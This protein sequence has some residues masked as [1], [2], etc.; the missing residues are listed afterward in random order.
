MAVAA[1]Y[2]ATLRYGAQTPFSDQLSH[3]W[4]GGQWEYDAMHDSIITAG[5]GGG[6]P[7]Q[8]AFTIFYDQGEQKYELEQ[9]L[10]PD[11]Q[12]WVDVGRLIRDQVPDKTGKVLPDTL[13]AWLVSI[14]RS[15]P[16]IERIFV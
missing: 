3:I 14:P 11:E 7:I 12:M 9:S 13:Q 2:D 8:A 16:F 1:S 10:E 6:K 15:E 4:E 5:N